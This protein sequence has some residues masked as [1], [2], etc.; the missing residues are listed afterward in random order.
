MLKKLA[1]VMGLSGLL[2]SATTQALP[3]VQADAF[4]AGDNKAALETATGLVWMDFGVNSHLSYNHVL[5]LLPTEFAG[6]RLPTA[7]EVDNLWTSLFGSLPEWNRYSPDFAFMA[8]HAQDDYFNSVFAVFGNS[9]DSYFESR[10]QDGN[11]VDSWTSKSLFAVFKNESGVSGY[12]SADSPYDD[13][14]SSTAMYLELAGTDVAGWFGTLLVKESKIQ[15][16][17]PS[18]VMLVLIGLLALLS[19]RQRRH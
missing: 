16:P 14:H 6:W 10:D 17:E 8:S 7:A 1:R 4:I 13:T 3:I 5:Y 9:P 18:G 2:L 12:V 19:R 15:V 11:V